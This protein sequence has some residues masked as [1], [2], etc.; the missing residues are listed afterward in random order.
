MG[1]MFNIGM[2]LVSVLPWIG[3]VLL[4]M[5]LKRRARE[6]HYWRWLVVKYGD[7]YG[8]DQTWL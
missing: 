8:R 6:V 1:E 7:R 5:Q 4:Y 2:L 3:C